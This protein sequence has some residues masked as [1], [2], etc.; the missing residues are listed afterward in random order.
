MSRHGPAR[1]MAVPVAALAVLV[2][3]CSTPDTSPVPNTLPT[4]AAS[5]STAVSRSAGAGRW[6]GLRT[7]CPDLRSRAAGAE[8]VTG[9][10]R[11][12]AD[13]TTDGANLTA[14]CRWGSTDGRGT[15]VEL[16]LSLYAAQPAADAAWRVLSAGQTAGL[17]GVG[18]EAFSSLEPPAVTVRVRSS[19]VVA[20][21]R[22]VT[23]TASASVERLRGLQPTATD[24]TQDVLDDLR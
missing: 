2:G 9:E 24:I 8:G 19:N 6:V 3:G 4:P 1:R 18:D 22:V 23:P 5:P 15:A 21:V 17:S 14:D 16:R 12:T 7:R 10:G 20:V 11:P 13:Y